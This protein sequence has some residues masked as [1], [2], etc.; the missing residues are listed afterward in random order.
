MRA[1]DFA[2]VLLSHVL[3]SAGF[4]RCIMQHRLP[5]TADFAVI[6]LIFYYDLGLLLEAAGYHYESLFFSSLFEADDGTFLLAML[7][8]AAAPWLFHAGSILTNR[9]AD[10]HP[11]APTTRLDP[12]RLPAFYGLL[13]VVAVPLAVYGLRQ[14]LSG[15]PLWLVRIELGL[16]WGPLIVVLYLPLHFLAFYVRQADA[17]TWRGLLV[18]GGLAG[19][20]LLS[21][22][23]IGERTMLLVPFLIL[24]IFRLR[25]TIA[26]LVVSAAV[27]V[28]IASALLPILR[29]Q[30]AGTDLGVGALVAETISA[31]VARS[32][33][34][35]TAL[36]LAEPV[37]TRLL[38]YPGAGY[39]YSVLFF[40]PRQWAPFKGGPTT[41]YFTGY[42]AG[43]P[44]EE[45]N[46]SLGVGVIEELILNLGLLAV[47]PGLLLYGLG[48]GL[49]D[50][51]S[52]RVP[53]LVVPTR[54]AAVWLCGYNLPALL[55]LFGVMVLI[56]L[57]LHLAFVQRPAAAPL[58]DNIHP[59]SSPV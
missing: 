33:V 14:L 8:L 2:I 5:N 43:T 36:E 26:R 58:P 11:Q 52:W 20:T 19:A 48:M 41:Q 30:Y 23:A 57:A 16:Q 3:A 34:L 50:R 12:A 56:G 22:A 35:D 55:N 59:V 37:G 45:T 25:M 49:L 13:A 18:A 17:H 40:V 44:P 21:T 46:W 54:L 4:W 28:V 31:D 42:L 6:S 39:V 47:V 32:G 29:W 10:H 15:T 1:V 53:A 7:F 51:L 9:R 38:P 27:L 24:A